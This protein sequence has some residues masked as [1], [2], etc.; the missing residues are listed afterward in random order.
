MS[1]P[2]LQV[3]DLIW[4]NSEFAYQQEVSELGL[5]PSGRTIVIG[6]VDPRVDPA[7]VMGLG[8]GEAIVIR[9]VGGRV[10]PAA[11]R[12]LALL[13]AIAQAEGGVAG[14]GWN[15]V[16]LHHTDCGITRLVDNQD[17]LAAELGITPDEIDAE[18]IVDPY[19]SLAADTAVLHANPLLPRGI[20][21][22]GLLYDTRTGRL[23]TVVPPVPLGQG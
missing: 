17:A 5:M 12:T 3:D 1:V 14:D 23:K 13:R 11:M 10:T 4:R 20:A 16:V 2:S 9:N 7:I 19:R 22:S 18:T 15:L 6:C 21:V 8:L